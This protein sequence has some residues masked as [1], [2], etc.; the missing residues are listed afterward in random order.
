MLSY[1]HYI[2]V[3]FCSFLISVN[4]ENKNYE[5]STTFYDIETNTYHNFQI[6]PAQQQLTQPGHQTS[7]CRN[8][9]ENSTKIPQPRILDTKN[10][11]FTHNFFVFVCQYD[12]SVAFFYHKVITLPLPLYLYWQKMVI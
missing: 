5:Q 3:C 10:H 2:L 1:L 9:S 6:A 7:D 4:A 12:F 8:E 11:Y